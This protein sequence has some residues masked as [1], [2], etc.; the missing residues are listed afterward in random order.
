MKNMS[1]FYKTV[2]TSVDLCL[3]YFLCWALLNMQQRK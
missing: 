2:E 1:D 3:A